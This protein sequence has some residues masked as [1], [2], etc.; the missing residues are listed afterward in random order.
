M[1]G[2]LKLK[3]MLGHGTPIIGKNCHRILHF[4]DHVQLNQL[5]ALW[6]TLMEFVDIL[7]I[8]I[9]IHASMIKSLPKSSLKF[10]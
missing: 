8:H 5:A 2:G 3:P 6:F 10:I 9:I 4:M 1:Q 7:S